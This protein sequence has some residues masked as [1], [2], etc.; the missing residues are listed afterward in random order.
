MNNDIADKSA[1]ELQGSWQQVMSRW[2]N[3]IWAVL[4]KANKV[5]GR[6]QLWNW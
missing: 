6:V 5:W 1:A 3:V 4:D 2:H